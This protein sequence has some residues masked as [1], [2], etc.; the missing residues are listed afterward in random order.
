M[1]QLL[2]C[3]AAEVAAVAAG[4]PA[5]LTL[6]SA[7]MASKVQQLKELTQGVPT[8]EKQLREATPQKL[9]SWA[10]FSSSRLQRLQTVAAKGLQE[11]SSISKVLKMNEKGYVQMISATDLQATDSC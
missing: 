10:C 7:T 9:A 1:Q 6:A 11:V 2:G 8:W 5:L 4:H 3:S